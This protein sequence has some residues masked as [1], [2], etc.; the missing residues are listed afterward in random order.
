MRPLMILMYCDI[1]GV[2]RTFFNTLIKDLAR[3]LKVGAFFGLAENLWA[4]WVA[5]P[6][7]TTAGGLGA[8]QGPQKL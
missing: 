6:K 3:N 8:A 5:S 1:F 7:P 4:S 2:L